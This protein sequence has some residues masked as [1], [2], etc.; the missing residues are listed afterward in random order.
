MKN[1]Y[2]DFYFLCVWNSFGTTDY[3]LL[4]IACD[5]LPTSLL[6]IDFNLTI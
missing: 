2:T 1:R 6:K 3:E 5:Y 4:V